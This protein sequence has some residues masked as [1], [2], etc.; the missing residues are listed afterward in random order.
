[1]ILVTG[2]TGTTGSQVVRALLEQ[3]QDVRAFVRDPDRARNLFGETVEPAVGDFAEPRSL[4]AA[5]A[6]TDTMFLSCSDDPRRVEWEIAAID[7]AAEA[8]VRRIVKLSSIVA[9][10]GST[11]AF[12]DWHGRVEQ[13]LRASSVPAVYLHASFFMTNLLAAAGQVASEG[14]LCAPAGDASF[15]MI[16]P[17]DVGA[18]AAAALTTSGHD[19]RTYALTGPEALTYAQVAVELSAATGHGVRFVDVPEEAARAGMVA[20]G[21]PDFAARQIV[22]IFARAKRGVGADVTTAVETLT[23]R[24]PRGLAGF[25]RAHARVFAPAAEA[26][27]R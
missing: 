15:A 23:G 6:G 25:A 19:G 21:L 20:A 7:A 16:D 13:H 3:R 4:R 22:E 8:G 12:W 24:P 14:V 26:V 10:Q 18:A 17:R 27:A 1:M 5:L 9:E 2:A 11:V